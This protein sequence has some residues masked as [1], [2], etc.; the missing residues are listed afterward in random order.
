MQVTF[1]QR[2]RRASERR[3]LIVSRGKRQRE[4]DQDSCLSSA[5]RESL[6]RLRDRFPPRG[7]A[8]LTHANFSLPL[9]CSPPGGISPPTS[10]S[11][12]PSSRSPGHFCPPHSIFRRETMM[13]G[14][15]REI[16]AMEG[17]EEEG[18]AG[19]WGANSSFSQSVEK[20]PSFEF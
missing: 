4:D 1:A 10:S 11:S 15:I 2:P 6:A 5:R 16:L 20:I 8:S 14:A 12:L 19:G 9:P 3:P 17:R 7:S 13:D 18:C